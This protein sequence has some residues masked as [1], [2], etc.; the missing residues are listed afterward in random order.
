MHAS[1][2]LSVL[3][4][5][6]FEGEAPLESKLL[7]TIP[8]ELSLTSAPVPQPDGSSKPD[9]VHPVF[10]TDGARVAYVA[11]KGAKSFPVIDS[12]VSSAGYDYAGAPVFSPNGT[13][14]GFRVGNRLTKSTERWWV[15]S[16]SG[17]SKPTDW[18]GEIA[19]LPQGG[20]TYW[21]QPGAKIGDD[22]AYRRSDMRLVIGS[23]TGGKFEDAETAFPPRVS[24][25]GSIV[26]TVAMKAGR[27][28]PLKVGKKEQLLGKGVG[29]VQGV[30]ISRD[31][32]RVA[33]E[34][35]AADESPNPT[36]LTFTVYVDDA[37]IRSGFDAAGCAVFSPDGK[38]VGYK[39][40]RGEKLGVATTADPQPKAWYEFVCSPVW[41]GDGRRMAY[42]AAEGSSVERELATQWLG[43][44]YAR[45][46]SWFVV[47]PGVEPGSKHQHV[48]GLCLSHDGAHV[49]YAARN[50]DRWS[51]VVDGDAG[52]ETYDFAGPPVFS[53]DGSTVAFGVRKEREL[54]WI[55]RDVPSR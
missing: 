14:V 50:D 11:W 9:V 54:C 30:A 47:V 24:A 36:E 2:L 46:G 7:A 31:G 39:V 52:D 35:L 22:G 12:T 5:V 4:V 32:K 16:D 26:A 55:V 18:M 21:T 44:D 51:I 19:A 3:L 43:E 13:S 48:R 29:L 37:P 10:S 27:W 42:V 25:D 34:G 28:F 41:S 23:H 1:S 49:A 17:L 33:Y 8:D 45:G 20:F 40:R 15:H 38:T 6:A 53:R